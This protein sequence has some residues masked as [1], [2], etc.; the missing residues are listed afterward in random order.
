[1][2]E[3]WK[4]LSDRRWQRKR[5]EILERAGFECESCGDASNEKQ[6]HIHHTYYEKG[7]EPWEYPEESL[8]CVCKDCHKRMEH[9]R[10]RLLKAAKPA[11]QERIIGYAK[12]L[13]MYN[14]E[15]ESVKL[16][17]AEEVIGAC[18]AL[19]IAHPAFQR[20]AERWIAENGYVLSYEI[21]GHILYYS[22]DIKNAAIGGL[23]K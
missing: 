6:L 12:G 21:T 16:D 23:S 5:L 17:S 10:L 22:E 11:D 15:A 3:Y 1:M 13:V 7:V 20:T 18:C 14:G 2:S 19:R 8:M 4:K 9:I